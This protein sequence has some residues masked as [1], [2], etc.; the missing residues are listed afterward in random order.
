MF[1]VIL[2]TRPYFRRLLDPLGIPI[3]KFLENP[4]FLHTKCQECIFVCITSRNTQHKGRLGLLNNQKPLRHVE[5]TVIR[6]GKMLQITA[7]I[8]TLHPTKMSV[9]TVQLNSSIDMEKK[10]RTVCSVYVGF[11]NLLFGP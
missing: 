10:G 4:T 8:G 3:R 2:T 7:T 1:A 11:M 5:F 9:K 6:R